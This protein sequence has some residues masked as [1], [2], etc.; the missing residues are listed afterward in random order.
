MFSATD[1]RKTSGV[2]K[3]TYFIS[4]ALFVVRPLATIIENV[5]SSK[6]DKQQIPHS[7]KNQEECNSQESSHAAHKSLKEKTETFTDAAY[8]YYRGNVDATAGNFSFG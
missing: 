5:A 2:E 6:E 7:R 4:S 8:D 3:R 1:I